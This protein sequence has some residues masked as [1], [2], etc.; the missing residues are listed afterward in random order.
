MLND[1][2]HGKW[3]SRFDPVGVGVSVLTHKKVALIRV[4][5][6]SVHLFVDCGDTVQELSKYASRKMKR[7]GK[8]PAMYKTIDQKCN[9][10]VRAWYAKHQR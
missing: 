9:E 4:P 8:V 2:T 10:A 3:G 6:T 7:Y 1:C 5:S